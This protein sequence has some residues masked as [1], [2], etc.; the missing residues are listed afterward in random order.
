V[1][2]LTVRLVGEAAVVHYWLDESEDISGQQLKTVYVETDTYRREHDSWMMVAM[3]LTVVPRD[4]APIP[5]ASRQWSVLTG[6]Y[7]LGVSQ[8][9]RYSVFERDHSLY[10]GRDAASARS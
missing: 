6:E 9:S 8:A 1:R 5:L 4:L 7:R 2:N 3:Q 10:M